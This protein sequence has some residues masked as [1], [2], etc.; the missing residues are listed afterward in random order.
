M[1]RRR[2]RHIEPPED[3]NRWLISYADFITLLFAFFVVMYAISSVNVGKYRVLS[4]SMIEAFERKG[5]KQSTSELTD[6]EGDSSQPIS[7]GEPATSAIEPV[8][9]DHFITAEELRDVEI[10]EEVLEERRRL[11]RIA[12]QFASALESFIDDDLVEVKKNDLWVEI[13]IKSGLLFASGD[14]A[15]Q[16]KAAPVLKKIS[17]VLQTTSNI[18]YVEGHTDNIPIETIEFP[19]N[20]DLSSARAVSVARELVNDGINPA[21]LAAVGYGDNH[22]VAD[23]KTAEGRFKNRRV[24]LVL[25]SNSLARYGGKNNAQ[26][27]EVAE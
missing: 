1:A 25:I 22:P 2:K 5:A 27:K 8:V 21:R 23:N 26:I 12:E 11:G 16:S 17:E 7:L 3:H 13:E 10:S 19:S 14:A 4:D 20:W 18:I 24:T 15:L 6:G 9:L